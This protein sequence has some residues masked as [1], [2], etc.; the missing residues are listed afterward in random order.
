[1]GSP[2]VFIDPSG[3]TPS[4]CSCQP[5]QADSTSVVNSIIQ[6][7][8][9][10]A[11]NA[12]GATP[13][14]IQDAIAGA[15]IGGPGS[16]LTGTGIEF[17]LEQMIDQGGIEG[18]KCQCKVGGGLLGYFPNSASAIKLCGQCVGTDKVG[19]FLEEGLVYHNIAQQ[20]GTDYAIAYGYWT[21][22]LAPPDSH[23][24]IA[25]WYWL[26]NDK[27]PSQQL[28]PSFGTIPLATFWTFY[29]DQGDG[30]GT[31]VFDPNGSASPA[32]LASNHSGMLFWDELHGSAVGGFQFDICKYMNGMNW[33][34]TTPGGQNVPG[35]PRGSNPPPRPLR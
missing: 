25:I 15:L 16:G 10:A 33:D 29:S 32:D 5:G 4:V 9:D 2:S 19:H 11:A 35:A 22:G 20:L 34:H 23:W 21:E 14:D 1:M 31:G 30:V 26:T 24:N 27:L 13:Q 3:L 7:V 18:E 6:Q 12:P 17:Q 8:I 28:G